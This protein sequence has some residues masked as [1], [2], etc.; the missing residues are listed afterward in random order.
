M[1]PDHKNAPQVAVALFR[2]R[3]KLLFAPG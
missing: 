2:D 3:A 1:P